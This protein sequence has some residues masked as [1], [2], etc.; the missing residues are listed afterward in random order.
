MQIV[1]GLD[2]GVASMRAGGVRRIYVPGNLSF[3]KGLA[4]GPGRYSSSASLPTDQCV[5]AVSHC[6]YQ[7]LECSAQALTLQLLLI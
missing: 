5:K 1:A 7:Q 4:S 2:E 6:S 3:P